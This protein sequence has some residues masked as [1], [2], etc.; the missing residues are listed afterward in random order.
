VGDI[1]R[2]AAEHYDVRVDGLLKKGRATS[3]QRRM[4][5]YLCKVLSGKKNVEVGKVF[6]VTIQAV[7]NVV[8][9]IEKIK[10]TGNELSKEIARIEKI[11]EKKN[12]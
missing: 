12:V 4:A 5:I 8:R 9:E 7:T 2:A 10:E 11:L 3:K 6:G 1:I